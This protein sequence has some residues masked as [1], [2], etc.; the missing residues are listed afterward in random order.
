MLGIKVRRKISGLM[1]PVIERS[2]TVIECS[3]YWLNFDTA[4]SYSEKAGV[5]VVTEGVDGQS[6][7][8]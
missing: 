1:K 6:A 7:T 8:S 5:V 4:T 3:R 2:N